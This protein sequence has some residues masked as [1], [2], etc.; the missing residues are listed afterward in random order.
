M[1]GAVSRHFDCSG[2]GVSSLGGHIAV[3]IHFNQIA[4]CGD[5]IGIRY[6]RII[7]RSSSK[8]NF[9]HF[10]VGIDGHRG[11]PVSR[12]RSRCDL[13]GR[14]S[15]AGVV[16]IHHSGSRDG[17]ASH[18]GTGCIAGNGIL[19]TAYPINSCRNRLRFAGIGRA[20]GVQRQGHPLQGFLAVGHGDNVGSSREGSAVFQ[21]VGRDAVILLTAEGR[22]SRRIGRCRGIRN[23]GAFFSVHPIP[24]ISN[25]A[26]IVV[27]CYRRICSQRSRR[28]TVTII[29]LTADGHNGC[30]LAGIQTA[31]DIDAT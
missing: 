24:L 21:G 4:S 9:V 18:I 20:A 23:F 16:A 5:T 10:A 13:P 3:I 26:A 8:G 28:L 31:G 22:Q 11:I 7:H 15:E 30:H 2:T 14:R 19:L 12:Q 6:R 27:I 1:V 25:G 17:V 29:G